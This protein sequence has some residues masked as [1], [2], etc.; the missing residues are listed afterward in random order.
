MNA[1]EH[2]ELV[3]A[4]V[5]SYNRADVVCRAIDSALNQTYAE[6]E[7]IVVD[8]GSTDETPELVRRKYADRPNVR[9]LRVENGGV[10][11]ARNI[12]IAA[13]TGAYI[14]FLDSDDIWLPWKI[15]LQVRCLELLPEAGMIWT[16]MDAID[17][18]EMMVQDR[19]LR[20][21]YHAYA[22]LTGLGVPVFDKSRSLRAG[23]LGI[24]GIET[25]VQLH[26]GYIFSQMIM[27]NLVHTSTCLL[28]RERLARVVGFRED[29]RVTGEDYDFHLRTC[30]EGDVAF[31]DVASIGYTIGRSDQLTGPSLSVFM[32]QNALR[33]VEPVLAESGHLIRLPRGAVNGMLARTHAWVGMTM[34]ASDRRAEARAHAATSIR[35]KPLVLRSYLLWVAAALPPRGFSSMRATLRA[36]RKL[37]ARIGSLLAW[38]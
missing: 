2:P 8:D 9:Y 5:P 1:K 18:G 4:I 35:H 29:L 23:E 28:R 12:G 30:R 37:K 33:T 21:M 16:D 7:V 32:A 13:A 15:E 14:A 20:K 31:I 24:R 17:D 38:Q 3:T 36:A 27:G 25:D 26:S 11:R 22:V 10:S 6:I 19:Y 34:I